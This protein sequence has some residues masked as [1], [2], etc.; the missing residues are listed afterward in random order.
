M[1]IALK[2]V[3]NVLTCAGYMVYPTYFLIEIRS[4]HN[5]LNYQTNKTNNPYT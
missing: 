5:F 2:A 1:R 4:Y 3:I